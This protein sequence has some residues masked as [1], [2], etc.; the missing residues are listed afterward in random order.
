MWKWF[1]LYKLDFLRNIDEYSSKLACAHV[2]LRHPYCDI[3]NRFSFDDWHEMGVFCPI[4]TSH[5]SELVDAPA[6][7]F[8]F[9]NFAGWLEGWLLI[10]LEIIDTFVQFAFLSRNP[11]GYSLSGFINGPK[12]SGFD[13]STKNTTFHPIIRV[14][15]ATATTDTI[16]LPDFT[17]NE[18]KAVWVSRVLKI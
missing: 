1:P 16:F 5:P 17:L 10:R 12:S 8:T 6:F 2:L 14:R 3:T 9:D 13:T 4:L 11:R 15:S 7:T 18:K